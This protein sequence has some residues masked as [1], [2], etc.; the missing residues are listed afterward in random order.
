MW[1]E[2]GWIKFDI[3]N[4]PRFCE[5]TK[6][7]LLGNLK[8]DDIVIVTVTENQDYKLHDYKCVDKNEI[9]F[10]KI[11]GDERPFQIKNFQGFLEYCRKNNF[12]ILNNKM[13]LLFLITSMNELYI[14]NGS[15]Y[16]QYDPSKDSLVFEDYIEKIHPIDMDEWSIVKS[17]FRNE[18]YNVIFADTNITTKKVDLKNDD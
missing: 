13:K 9:I 5:G 15:Y 3:N 6:L 14:V 8:L 10:Y 18:D 11:L 16:C 4:H 1:N 2:N 17:E 12:M 7:I